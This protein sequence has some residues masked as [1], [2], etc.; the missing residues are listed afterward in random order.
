MG[1]FSKEKVPICRDKKLLSRG[2]KPRLI[3]LRKER[4]EPDL[5]KSR[6]VRSYL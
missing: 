1:A 5:E 2:K 3:F 4:F 6:A